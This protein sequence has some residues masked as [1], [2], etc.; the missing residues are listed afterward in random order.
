MIPTTDYQR[1]G[2]L[3]SYDPAW[4][5]R[6]E[7]AVQLRGNKRWI[8]DLGC[9]GRQ[10]L[11]KLL[12]SEVVY[13]PSDLFRW[14][15]DTLTCD[16]NSRHLPT[17]YLK[18]CDL[19]YI[20]GV[21]EY[22]HDTTW[23]FQQLSRYVEG[24]GFSYNPVDFVPDG[25]GGSGWVSSLSMKDLDDLL[26]KSEF[27]VAEK[28]KFDNG[29][30]IFKA[31]ARQF[32]AARRAERATARGNFSLMTNVHDNEA[33]PAGSTGVPATRPSTL[34]I[35]AVVCTFMRY[36][37]LREAVESLRH[38]TL[39]SSR[40]E[41]LIIDNSPDPELS[42]RASLDYA[43]IGNLRWIY[44]DTPGEANARN[45]ALA[46]ATAPIVA[47]LDDDATASPGW[48]EAML[49]GFAT[50]DDVMAVGGKVNPVWGAPR[51]TWLHDDL[52][53]YLSVLDWGEEL[54]AIK[55]GEW[56]VAAN[57]A[58]RVAA[59]TK[60]GGFR[61]HL[62]RRL[63]EQVL[64]SNCEMD[65][66]DM[67][68]SRGFRAVYN[69]A[70]AIDH[71]INPG[72]L[73][74]TWMR[75][76]AVWQAVS[77]YLTNP[78]GHS[79]EAP[80]VRAKLTT[81]LRSAPRSL[82]ER[83]E[84]PGRFA[85]QIELLRNLAMAMLA[86]F[87]V[88]AGTEEAARP[89]E[90]VVG[91]AAAE[92]AELTAAAPKPA[93]PAA[94]VG[95]GAGAAA[96]RGPQVQ[97]VTLYGESFLE[98]Y[99][100]TQPALFTVRGSIDGLD[101]Q[102][103]IGLVIAADVP[104]DINA[105]LPK[106][107]ADSRLRT[108]LKT[109]AVL[110][111]DGSGE[112]PG[113]SPSI[114]ADLHASLGTA[115]IDP[116]RAIFLTQNH[117]YRADYDS[118]RLSN[119][120]NKGIVAH[121]F[122]WY[123]RETVAVISTMIDELMASAQR[124]IRG[125]GPTPSRRYICL[126]NK[127]R[128]HR[129]IIL[130]RLVVRKLLARGH[131][132]FLGGH[133]DNPTFSFDAAM[134]EASSVF[135]AF[136]QEL[137]AFRDLCANPP[138]TVTGDNL[139]DHLTFGLAS[140]LRLHKD[141]AFS[142]VTETEMTTWGQIRRF[143]EKSL[144]PLAFG[145]P[146]IVAGYP[147]TLALLRAYGFRTFYPVIDESYDEIIDP[148]K[149]LQM[150]LEEFERLA[151]LPDVEMA[152]IN[153]Q[154][155]ETLLYNVTVFERHLP[156]RLARED[157]WLAWLLT[158]MS[159]GAAAA[160]R[161]SPEE[162]ATAEEAG[163][164]P[165]VQGTPNS[166]KE[167]RLD[168]SESEPMP[169][170]SQQLAPQH[171]PLE[172][173]TI[174]RADNPVDLVE[175]DAARGT[176]VLTVLDEFA[177]PPHVF[178]PKGMLVP[179]EHRLLYRVACHYY[180]GAGAIID[181]G[182]FCGASAYAMAAGVSDNTG[183]FG[184]EGRIHCYDLFIAEDHYTKNYLQNNFY[185]RFDE[186]GERVEVIREVSP[187]ESFL[188]IFRFQ[189]QRYEN[190]INVHAGSILD[191]QWNGGPIEILFIDVCKTLEIQQHIFREFL[192]SLI[193][194]KSILIQQDFHHPWH[195]YIHVAMEYLDSYFEIV[196]SAVGASRAYRLHSPIPPSSLEKAIRHEFTVA[197]TVELFDRTVRKAPVGERPLLWCAMA[198]QLFL[199][200][201]VDRCRVLISHVLTETQGRG[202]TYF[203]QLLAGLC[204]GLHEPAGRSAEAA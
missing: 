55:W 87:D 49:S 44:E 193:P 90:F 181:A 68:R 94:I 124:R 122:H 168:A 1:W 190:L 12:P 109:R 121:L 34:A 22:V 72:R 4:D 74:Q 64:M 169:E 61:T 112:G 158:A 95:R 27:N 172:E 180:S 117:Q 77:D 73:S 105:Y 62:G 137:Q 155:A 99:A 31:V 28:R 128:G 165:S 2:D 187:G 76:R 80:A 13:L 134:G 200:G 175:F 142:L 173:A 202:A 57:L 129:G 178:L 201:E 186:N 52:L 91:V 8:C 84:D 65:V 176:E 125:E 191:K 144:K 7:A 67:L 60:V 30:V 147:G 56:L 63:G 51:P 198:R 35:S 10:I 26:D 120:I 145:H 199:L 21:L 43:A 157:D 188:E 177:V 119:G 104:Q 204:P 98:R 79:C 38:Q 203:D 108:L 139:S 85:E 126:N 182:A 66:I 92:L 163:N 118:W 111:M 6:A 161:A 15:E 166:T 195:P 86:G 183:T 40:Y 41:I 69:P 102:S 146:M 135:P 170:P 113:F 116:A 3:A 151:F 194:E 9:G 185:S 20:L 75:R 167:E 131:V 160:E 110:I 192:P 115:G 23:L 17:S 106:V 11:R 19:C 33:T 78:E 197:E 93:Q 46:H 159:R 130:G 171:E 48:L 16:I 149:R 154:L 39:D 133:S 140:Q 107:L 25:R 97:L 32:D 42:K 138:L 143:T 53:G 152:A 100:R 103:P 24:V 82:T 114:A 136:P 153:Q 96:M 127:A 196:V 162:T 50:G 141:A 59:V 54:R 164:K 179:G 83:T 36:D 45:V 189:T 156:E 88:A 101:S 37:L 71:V 70:A 132:S 58:F 174:G 123:M 89:D 184:K 14:T 148:Q 18:I 150:V 5:S 29:T 81:L 47:Y